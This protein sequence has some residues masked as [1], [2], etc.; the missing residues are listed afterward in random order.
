MEPLERLTFAGVA[1]D[2]QVGAG[3]VANVSTDA[4]QANP[5]AGN[6]GG[7]IEQI[8]RPRRQICLGKGTV[9]RPG[10]VQVALAESKF[11]SQFE[12]RSP[13]LATERMEAIAIDQAV[14]FRVAGREQLSREG[15]QQATAQPAVM[16]NGRQISAFLSPRALA[17]HLA[18]DHEVGAD[19]VHV[20]TR[21]GEQLDAAVEA[22]VHAP[23]I[24]ETGPTEN[25][26]ERLV[27]VPHGQGNLQ[28]ITHPLEMPAFPLAWHADVKGRDLH[29][30]LLQNAN[31]QIAVESA[32]DQ[33]DGL[34]GRRS[35]VFRAE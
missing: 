6:L 24:S 25:L 16:G 13:C 4:E 14:E 22:R 3:V 32:R 31:G 34:G 10:L 15:S 17:E 5:P 35:H 26:Y 20:M 7:L 30:L 8:A 23:S 19:F 27:G 28:P 33:R 2:H 1:A 9:R 21:L 11:A 29:L 18:A 12:Q